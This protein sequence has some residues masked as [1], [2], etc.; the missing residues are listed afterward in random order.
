MKRVLAA[1]RLLTYYNTAEVHNQ[2]LHDAAAAGATEKL[3]LESDHAPVVA[4]F[5]LLDS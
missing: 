4:K 5:G 1:W 3:F 2:L